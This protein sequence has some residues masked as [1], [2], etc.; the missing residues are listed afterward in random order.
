[1]KKSKFMW[2]IL[3]LILLILTAL[4]A[5]AAVTISKTSATIEVGKS[6]TLKV[7]DNGTAVS[8]AMWGSS[9][10]SVA[11]VSNAG[12]VTGKAAGSAA[13]TAMYN[14]ATFE[15][16]VSV[17]KS[18]TAKTVRYNVLILDVSKSMKGKPLARA[19]TAAKRFAKAV[20]ASDGKNYVALVSLNSSSKVKCQLT[21]SLTKFNSAVNSLTAGGNTNMR[22]AMKNAYDMLKGVSSGS[23]V[24]KNVVICADGL[25]NTGTK[26]TGGRYKKADHTYYA[27]ANACYKLDTSIK[28]SGQFVYALGFFHNSSGNNLTFGK[29]F[30]KD[31]ASKDKY[32]EVEDVDDINDV[33]NDIVDEITSVTI[34]ETSLTMYVGDTA[35]LTAYKNGEAASATWKSSDNA[36]ATVSGTGKV[37]AK[38]KGSCTITATISG[39]SVTCK[40]TV[41]VRPSIKLNKTKAIIYVGDKLTLKATVTGDSQSVT[42][43]SSKESVAKVR[44]GGVVTGVKEGTATITALANGVKAY[45]NVTVKNNGSS[46]SFVYWNGH[47]YQLIDSGKGCTWTEAYEACER[48]GGHLVTITSKE[49]HEFLKTL[50]GDRINRYCWIGGRKVSGKWTWITGETWTYTDWE[51]DQPN[52]SGGGGYV[53]LQNYSGIVK[54]WNW[55]DQN[56]SGTS[57]SSIWNSAPYYQ[58]TSSYFYICEWDY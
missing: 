25:P 48:M 26:T 15:C 24:M 46:G 5:S 49:E 31:L 10:T 19:K 20:L 16:V 4:P 55:D 51:P 53:L 29:R 27:Y 57:P 47:K 17:I 37:T 54:P 42:W 45:C 9:D 32:H 39:K 12:K 7:L 23:S 34:S 18:T 35:K 58:R 30:M 41:K 33:I 13:I 44:S 22:T 40:V 11:T 14:G 56:N 38:G 6:I 1:M 36:V 50:M 21:T 3:L 28:S 8:G 52:G 43:K 2:G